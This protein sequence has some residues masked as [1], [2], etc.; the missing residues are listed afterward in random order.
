MNCNP[1]VVCLDN[2]IQISSWSVISIYALVSDPFFG[3]LEAQSPAKPTHQA[4]PDSHTNLVAHTGSGQTH[5][6]AAP[7]PTCNNTF[8]A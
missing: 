2:T 1:V 3:E 6:A 5:S 7:R 4:A 8:T